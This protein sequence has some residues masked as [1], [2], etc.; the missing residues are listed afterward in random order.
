M[1][2]ARQF[3]SRLGMFRVE[4]QDVQ[5]EPLS[6]LRAFSKPGQPQPRFGAGRFDPDGSAQQAGRFIQV[7][8]LGQAPGCF[9]RDLG[10][11]SGII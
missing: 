6:L 5:K 1:V 3:R 10:T 7:S 11:L 8:L 9:H 2:Q 4:R